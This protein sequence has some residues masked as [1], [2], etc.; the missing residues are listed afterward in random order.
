MRGSTR[1]SHLADADGDDG[2]L[3]AAVGLSNVGLET[4]LLAVVMVDMADADGVGPGGLQP[5]AARVQVTAEF[6]WP[7]LYALMLVQ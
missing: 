4:G 7:M 3:K 6:L 1:A 5:L 2:G